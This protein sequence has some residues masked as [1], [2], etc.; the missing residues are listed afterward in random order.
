M[1]TVADLAI[2]TEELSKQYGRRRGL[3]GLDLSVQTGEVYGFLGPNGA[4]KTTTI[5]ILLDLIRPSGG[6]VT[7]LGAQPRHAGPV[8]RRRIGYLPGDFTVDGRQSAGELLAY[9]GNLRGGV[10]AAR[11]QALAERLDLDL[12][13]RIRSLSKGNRQKVGLLQAFM[14]EPELLVLDEPTSG[15]DPLLQ[16]TFVAMVREAREAGRTVFMSSHVMSEVQHTAD[17]V[18]IVRDGRMVAVERVEELRERA[19]RSVEI[20]FAEPVPPSEFAALP[21]VSDVAVSGSVLHCRLSGRADAL[22]K[23]AARHTVVSLLS[24]EP[25]LEELFFTYYRGTVD[26]AV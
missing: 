21:G 2:S 23:A 1:N 9:L 12:G 18:G 3:A 26:A 24:E 5:R 6:S 11:I 16:Q 10:P 4:G 15:L 22:V 14:H 25:D 19:V 17:R 8:L 7:V 20:H 13:A